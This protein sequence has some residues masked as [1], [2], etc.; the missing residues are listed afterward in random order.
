MGR[1]MLTIWFKLAAVRK[2]VK[3]RDLLVFFFAGH[4]VREG[5]EFFLLTHDADLKKLG[6]TALSGSQL[7]QRLADFP[8][9]VLLLFDACHS[10]SAAKSLVA[11]VASRQLADEECGAAL[12]RRPGRQH[13]TGR[14]FVPGPG[15]DWRHDYA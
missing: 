1:W 12:V 3:P 15:G 8:C 13:R 11:D 14:Y 5:R 2:K 10:G 9:Q 6:K 4:G 7:R